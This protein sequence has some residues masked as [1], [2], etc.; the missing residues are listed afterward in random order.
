MNTSATDVYILEGARTPFGSFGG[1]FKDTSATDLGVV[2]AKGAIERSKVKPE[3]VDQV[4]FGN[5]IQTSPDAIY[6]ARHVGLRSGVPEEVPALTLNRLCGSGTQAIISGAQVI[7]LGEA[8]TVLAGGAENMSQAPFLV[9]GAR[10]GLRLG[11]TELHDY[12]WESLTDSYC[13]FDMAHTA[14]NLADR[15]SVTREETDEFALRSQRLAREAQ[16]RCY[17]IEEIVP[18][19]VKGRK[20]PEEVT[21]DEHPRPDT[22]P[23]GLAK[24]KPYFKADGVVTAG[25]ASGI[26]DGASAVVLTTGENLNGSKPLGRIISWAVV[27]VEPSVMGIGP[28]RAIP[29][30][31]ERAGLGLDDVDL[32]E[33]NEAFSAQYLA[34]EKE[35]GLDRQKVNVNGG[36]IAIGHPLA[37]SGTRL[38]LTLLRE[39]RRRGGGIGVASACIGGGQGIALVVEAI[40]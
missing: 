18:V 20:G 39:L 26:V 13:N 3:Q 34:V 14:E 5:V 32:I 15:Y 31:L 28:A 40:G 37:A 30:A 22:T 2:A 12:L 24:L 36:A 35:L 33:V 16:E 4:F 7:Q 38:P 21:R 10:W 29:K 17:F 8:T 23:E 6:L 11:N 19:T 27:G 25:N 1:S 9:R